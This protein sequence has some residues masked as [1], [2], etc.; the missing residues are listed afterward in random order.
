MFMLIRNL[1][2]LPKLA[3]PRP[4]LL[5]YLRREG[6]IRRDNEADLGITQDIE[7]VRKQEDLIFQLVTGT[8]EDLGALRVKN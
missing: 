1:L 6:S 8:L 7:D 2:R 3:C 4:F 5:L